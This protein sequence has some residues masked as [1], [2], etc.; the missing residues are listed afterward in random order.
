MDSVASEWEQLAIALGFEVADIDCVKRNYV[1]DVK[2]ACREILTKW[3][4]GESECDSPI[5]WSTLIQS[6]IDAGQVGITEDL[7]ETFLYYCE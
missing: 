3:L 7:Q 5:T 2:G 1:Q 4:N 6:L